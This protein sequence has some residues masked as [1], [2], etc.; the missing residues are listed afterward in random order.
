MIIFR[1]C[2]NSDPEFLYVE[3]VNNEK[4]INRRKIINLFTFLINYKCL[5]IDSVD[6]KILNKISAQNY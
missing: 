2:Y 4:I 1:V 6:N 5:I 3:N